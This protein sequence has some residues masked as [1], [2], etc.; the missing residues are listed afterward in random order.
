MSQEENTLDPQQ[1]QSMQEATAP[2]GLWPRIQEAAQASL[3]DAPDV[4]TSRADSAEAQ[5]GPILRLLRGDMLR[6]SAAAMLGFFTFFGLQQ[7]ITSELR[8]E[9]QTS[10]QASGLH[11]VDHLG[12][13]PLFDAEG[14]VIIPDADP[15]AWP[16]VVL[17]TYVTTMESH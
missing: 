16:E 6:L 2:A 13:V 4:V 5:G 10:A 11:L 14:G 12:G 15:S 8:G 3:M 7:V 1:R 17:A 9:V